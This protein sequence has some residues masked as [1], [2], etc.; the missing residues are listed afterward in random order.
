MT[1]FTCLFLVTLVSLSC[2]QRIYSLPSDDKCVCDVSHVVNCNGESALRAELDL[3]KEIMRQLL[4]A[5]S[6]FSSAGPPGI[7]G[8][9]GRDGTVGPPGPPGPPGQVGRDGRDGVVSCPAGSDGTSNPK[10]AFTLTRSTDLG[11]VSSTAD[12]AVTFDHVL[13]DVGGSFTDVTNPSV[14]NCQH[15]GVYQF[16]FSAPSSS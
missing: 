5:G 1:M 7:P 12:L 13:T 8:R 11:V 15:P 2:A 6:N 4:Q 9:D 16:S 14:F 3:L 10:V